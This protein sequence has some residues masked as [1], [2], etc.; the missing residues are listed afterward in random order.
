MKTIDLTRKLANG[1][2][3]YPG[4]P[5]PH[6]DRAYTIVGSGF[7]ETR[8]CL[9]SHV[10]THID[11]P[12]HMVEGGRTLDSYQASAFFGKG[13]V[14]NLSRFPVETD[15]DWEGLSQ[16]ERE[17]AEGCGFL[18]FDTGFDADNDAFAPTASVSA[19]LLRKALSMG[20]GAF[21]IDRMS[22][23]RMGET[24]MPRHRLLFSRDA[25]IIENLRGLSQ[26]RGTRF[27]VVALPLY[28]EN[29]DG[30]P[31]RV[32]ARVEANA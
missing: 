18:L 14:I 24:R 3:V 23:D 19:G 2:Q 6:F 20:I 12:A 1:M 9:F 4:T 10:G 31:A 30:A 22:I 11:A 7:C 28:F 5:S 15:V 21:G 29:A 26:L 13:A 32:V 16:A 27:D 25:L 8:L 17:A